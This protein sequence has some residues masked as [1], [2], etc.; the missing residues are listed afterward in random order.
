MD[1]S[2]FTVT[3]TYPRGFVDKCKSIGS[4]VRVN[5]YTNTEAERYGCNYV[6]PSIVPETF[7]T[8]PLE[9]LIS[10][11]NN[12]IKTYKLSPDKYLALNKIS[13]ILTSEESVVKY[14][15]VKLNGTLG[16]CVEVKNF[17]TSKTISF[18]FITYNPILKETKK[19]L[20][21][22]FNT[23][24]IYKDKN[25]EDIII[26]EG[27]PLF[28]H[29]FAIIIDS[30]HFPNPE[31][32]IKKNCTDTFAMITLLELLLKKKYKN[33]LNFHINN[34]PLP[35]IEVELKLDGDGRDNKDGEVGEDDEWDTDDWVP[36]FQQ[37]IPQHLPIQPQCIPSSLIQSTNIIEPNTNFEQYDK[38]NV[39]PD[40][41]PDEWESL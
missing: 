23:F 24:L 36:P 8:L 19:H 6:M 18:P 41:I 35:K 31:V 21:M 32:Q 34:I 40:E 17:D 38:T 39:I 22:L 12:I 29:L 11:F 13:D 5:N 25:K 10:T 30:F 9:I 26:Y 33:I 2:T 16:R 28:I 1:Q 4:G 3:V 37:H 27:H 15:L 14:A 20:L 7:I